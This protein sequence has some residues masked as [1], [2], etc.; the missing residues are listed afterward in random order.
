M[1]FVAPGYAGLM[2]RNWQA[3]TPR[4]I[5][6]NDSHESEVKEAEL[7]KPPSRFGAWVLQR[8]DCNE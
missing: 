3:R 5:W 8:P 7:R 1:S 6:F 4:L 2:A